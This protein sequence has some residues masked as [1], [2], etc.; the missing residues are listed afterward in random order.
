MLSFSLWK[1]I[2]QIEMKIFRE[3]GSQRSESGDIL[4][5]AQ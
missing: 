1:V 2:E 5:E 4:M 3:A